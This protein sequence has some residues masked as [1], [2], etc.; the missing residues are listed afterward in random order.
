MKTHYEYHCEGSQSLSLLVKA[1]IGTTSIHSYLE[2]VSILKM[3]I[4]FEIT[5]HLLGIYSIDTQ[6]P[7]DR[8]PA[9]FLGALLITA[10][11]YKCPVSLLTKDR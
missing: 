2:D 5:I 6:M 9:S 1:Q 3:P 8:Y 4:P 10:K 7:T 11:Y